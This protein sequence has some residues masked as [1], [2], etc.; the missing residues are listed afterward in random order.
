M[1]DDK[2]KTRPQDATRVN[3]NEDYEVQYWTNKFG[4]SKE[5]LVNAVNAVGTSAEKVE[6]YLKEK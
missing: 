2:N 3:I 5:E 4:C 1:S 6:A